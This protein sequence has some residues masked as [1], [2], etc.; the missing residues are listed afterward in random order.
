MRGASSPARRDLLPERVSLVLVLHDVIGQLRRDPEFARARV[1]VIEPMPWVLAHRPTLAAVVSNLL[2]NAAKFVARG[3][4]P[5]VVVRAEDRGDAA[6]VWFQDNGIGI[7]PE[8]HE[9]IF[10]VFERLHGLEQF[11]GTGIGLAVVRRGVERMGGRVGVESAV[12]TGSRFWI[13]LPKDPH[14]P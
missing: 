7:A 14:G 10:H 12:G 1:E 6:R 11:P 3:V 2:E 5:V 9:R 13:E 4:D 8:H